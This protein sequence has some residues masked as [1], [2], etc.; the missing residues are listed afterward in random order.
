M[1]SA[2]RILSQFRQTGGGDEFTKTA[3][4]FA[5]D[6]MAPFR[7]FLQDE[8]PLIVSLASPAR[9][10]ILTSRHLLILRDHAVTQR[11]PL[12]NIEWV[13]TQSNDYKFNGGNL[14][15]KLRDGSLVSIDLHSGRP[16][17]AMMSVLMYIGRVTGLP[18]GRGLSG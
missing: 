6:Q 3:T 14:G 8:Q 9:S 12:E 17:I 10:F 7:E 5:D 15:V 16:Y 1:I 2:S 4:E 13:V 11:I 18:S